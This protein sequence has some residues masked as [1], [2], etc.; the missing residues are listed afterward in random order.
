MRKYVLRNIFG[1]IVTILFILRK[2]KKFELVS[3]ANAI[4]LRICI[5]MKLSLWLK[6]LMVNQIMNKLEEIIMFEFVIWR[7]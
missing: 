1:K 5:L 7:V 3:F 4:M 6:D 2:V